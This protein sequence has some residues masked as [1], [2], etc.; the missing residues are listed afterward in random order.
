MATRTALSGASSWPSF[1][2]VANASS[3]NAYCAAATVASRLAQRYGGTGA[4]IRSRQAN[5]AADKT[6]DLRAC[7]SAIITLATSSRAA[8]TKW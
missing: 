4:P 6:T 7:P 5:A 1:H 8:A 3:P 2:A